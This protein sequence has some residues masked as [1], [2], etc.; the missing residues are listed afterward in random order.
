MICKYLMWIYF[1]LVA[2]IK[3]GQH[4]VGASELL[5]ALHRLE[6]KDAE[7]NALLLASTSSSTFTLI[8][9][10]TNMSYICNQ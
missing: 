8:S 4:P 9:M 3:T 1:D 2:G 5:I 6:T 10:I 7:S